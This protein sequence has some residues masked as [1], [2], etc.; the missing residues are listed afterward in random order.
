MRKNSW[1]LK[2]FRYYIGISMLNFFN[3]KKK[4][5]FIEDITSHFREKMMKK[6]DE[7][8]GQN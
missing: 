3:R 8:L 7:E 2:L 4:W 6:N 5:K 1:Y